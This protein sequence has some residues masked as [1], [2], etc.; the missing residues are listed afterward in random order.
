MKKELIQYLRDSNGQPRGI[1]VAT[2]A[3]R[4]GWSAVH[5]LDRF[6]K[7]LALRIARGRAEA[8]RSSSVL[9]TRYQGVYDQMMERSRAYF[10]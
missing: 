7:T 2:G 8:G 10:K 4:V 9:P 6:D 1:V 5:P 3:G